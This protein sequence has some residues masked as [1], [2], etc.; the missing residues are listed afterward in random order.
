MGVV[1][2][3]AD[4]PS[5]PV[6]GAV[7]DP[8]DLRRDA[9]VDAEGEIGY[10]AE[11]EVAEKDDLVSAAVAR[12]E[13]VRGV[14]S[15]VGGVVVDELFGELEPGGPGVGLFRVLLVGV[16][17]ATGGRDLVGHD[18]EDGVGHAGAVEGL[19]SGVL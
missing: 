8:G 18:G 3:S 19:F 7:F 17:A 14:S 5:L 11:T 4:G 10:E 9:R 13:G 12:E 15:A 2:H 1:R 16:G 6:E